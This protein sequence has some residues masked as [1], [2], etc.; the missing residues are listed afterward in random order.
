MDNELSTENTL[1]LFLA[2]NAPLKMCIS[3]LNA[4]KKETVCGS[5]ACYWVF[6]CPLLLN[7]GGFGCTTKSVLLRW[8]AVG[9][10]AFDKL[11]YNRNSIR[12]YCDPTEIA[13]TFAPGFARRSFVSKKQSQSFLGSV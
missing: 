9:F 7:H 12:S 2:V 3:S 13:R 6:H 10:R 8:F 5:L 1:F 4:A 11:F